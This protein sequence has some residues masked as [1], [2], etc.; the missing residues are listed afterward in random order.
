M[1]VNSIKYKAKDFYFNLSLTSK[2]FLLTRC[3]DITSIRCFM[4]LNFSSYPYSCY[5]SET[6]ESPADAN[7]RK[8]R[9]ETTAGR[10]A[11]WHIP[12]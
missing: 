5:Q 9:Q 10:W 8:G 4:P 3:L 6:E 11:G 2:I 12:S 7:S 1:Y